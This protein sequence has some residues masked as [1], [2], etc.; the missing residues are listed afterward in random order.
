MNDSVSADALAVWGSVCAIK[1]V[2]ALN[3]NEDEDDNE[4]DNEDVPAFAM[5]EKCVNAFPVK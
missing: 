3:D 5:R 1:F 2:I 4:D